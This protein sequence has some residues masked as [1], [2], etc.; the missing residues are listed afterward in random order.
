MMMEFAN[1]AVGVRAQAYASSAV[2][3]VRTRG[4]LEL[5]D[6]VWW[7]VLEHEIAS[8]FYVGFHAGLERIC[9]TRRRK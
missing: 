9:S 7:T 1:E 6:P 4:E 8:A 5:G 2:D 3:I